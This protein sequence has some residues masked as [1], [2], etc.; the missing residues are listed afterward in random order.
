M[1][2]TDCKEAISNRIQVRK[3]KGGGH[4]DVLA[5]LQLP[6]NKADDVCGKRFFE[7]TDYAAQNLVFLQ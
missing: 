3:V 6:G 4:A 7:F 2:K 5:V 1:V